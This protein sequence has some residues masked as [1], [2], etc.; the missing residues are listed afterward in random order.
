MLSMKLRLNVTQGVSGLI[1]VVCVIYLIKAFQL[2]FGT[3]RSPGVGFLPVVSGVGAT[4]LSLYHLIAS[5]RNQIESEAINWHK[6]GIFGLSLLLYSLIIEAVGY[7]IATLAL[8]LILIKLFGGS[9]WVRPAVISVSVAY[10]SYYIF[11]ELL[12]VP[13][14]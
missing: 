10:G 7:A 2:K 12:A 8:L 14:P 6:I 4:I 1:F 9:G 5:F 13:L 3:F 11:S